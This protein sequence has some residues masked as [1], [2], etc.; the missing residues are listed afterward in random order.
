MTSEKKQKASSQPKHCT[1]KQ[2]DRGKALLDEDDHEESGDYLKEQIR[3]LSLHQQDSPKLGERSS[4]KMYRPWR[5]ERNHRSASLEKQ[6]KA[7]EERIDKQLKRFQAQYSRA[8]S[9]IL[10]KDIAEL[11]MPK[12]TPPLELTTLSWFGDWRPSS[13]LDLL[14]SLIKST[15]TLASSLAHAGAT[16]KAISQMIHD[17]RIEEAII[18][19]EMTEIQANCIL[20]L[21]FALAQEKHSGTALDQVNAELKKVH[22]LIV[23]AQNFRINALETV[24]KKVLCQSD[25]AEFLVAFGGIQET[26][27]QFSRDYKMRKGPVCV[28][29]GSGSELVDVDSSYSIGK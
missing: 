4:W 13:I 16:E 3:C 7:L 26:V 17:L 28:Q 20:N 10:P 21:P 5:Q 8:S 24:V 14:S 18:D 1:W 6:L 25:A 29:M 15:P 12:S 2:D 19:E 23:K 11:L 9:L 22:R 27:H